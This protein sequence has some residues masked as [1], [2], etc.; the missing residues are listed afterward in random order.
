MLGILHNIYVS[1]THF[2]LGLYDFFSGLRHTS[3]YQ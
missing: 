3:W 2:L 1:F